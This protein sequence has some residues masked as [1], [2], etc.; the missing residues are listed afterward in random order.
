MDPVRQAT[1]HVRRSVSDLVAA[2]NVPALGRDYRSQTMAARKLTN[3]MNARAV[4]CRDRQDIADDGAFVR[5]I[6]QAHQSDAR[7]GFLRQWPVKIGRQTSFGT[8]FGIERWFQ[9]TVKI[10]P[11]QVVKRLFRVQPV[12]PAQPVEPF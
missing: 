8:L 10:A 5:C 12:T 11:H 9:A 4:P 3:Q 6:L 2:A 7:C 1:D